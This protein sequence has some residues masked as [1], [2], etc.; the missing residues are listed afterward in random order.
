MAAKQ[1]IPTSTLI[2]KFIDQ[3]MSIEKTKDDID[4]I[5]KQIREELETILAPAISR[6]MKTLITLNGYTGTTAHYNTMLA[7]SILGKKHDYHQMMEEAKKEA[8][9][10]LGLKKEAIDILF[11]EMMKFD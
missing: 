9:R 6:I 7:A 5:R 8:A 10:K 3:G 1:G 11:E 4:F 2:R